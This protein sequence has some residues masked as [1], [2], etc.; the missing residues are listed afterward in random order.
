MKA[1]DAAV[2]GNVPGGNLLG[3]AACPWLDC[4]CSDQS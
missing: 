3:S 2:A 4:E 1:G